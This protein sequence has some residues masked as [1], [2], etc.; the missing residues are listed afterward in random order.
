MNWMLGASHPTIEGPK[1]YVRL[2]LAAN[3]LSA[4]Y[5]KLCCCFSQQFH[6]AYTLS[7]VLR[8]W[9]DDIYYLRDSK[10]VFS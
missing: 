9:I 6:K 7:H 10:D 5:A 1:Y 8:T 3:G 4:I 2:P